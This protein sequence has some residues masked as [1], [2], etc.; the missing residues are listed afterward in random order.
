MHIFEAIKAAATSA[1]RSAADPG[2]Y[3]GGSVWPA[4]AQLCTAGCHVPVLGILE[5]R[6]E[7]RRGAWS[8]APSAAPPARSL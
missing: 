6:A 4:G 2:P 3:A 8:P 5:A 7:G 1:G